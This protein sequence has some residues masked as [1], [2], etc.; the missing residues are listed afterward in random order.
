MKRSPDGPDPKLVDSI[1]DRALDLPREERAGFVQRECGGDDRLAGRLLR[2]LEAAERAEAFLET[3]VA[4][5]TP[6]LLDDLLGRGSGGTQPAP[7]LVLGRYRILRE[8]GRG[9]MGAVYLAERAD[10]QYERQVA[11]KLVPAGLGGGAFAK[12]FE[13]ERRILA[14]LEHPCI[15]RLYDAGSTPEGTPYLVMEYVEG[16]PIDRY[17]EEEDLSVDQRL[18]LFEQVCRA[19]E[20]AHG[21]LIVH[22]DLKPSNILVT[23]DGT[24]KLLDFGVARLLEPAEDSDG[25]ATADP[26]TIGLRAL[27]PEYASPEQLRGERVTT[28]A[29]VWALGVLLYRLLAGRHPYRFESRSPIEVERTITD[30]PPERPSDA[31][32]SGDGSSVLARDLRGD[33]DNVVLA[34]LRPDPA[35]RYGPAAALRTDLQNYLA[36]FP[37]RARPDT[38]RYRAVKFVRRHRA[39][40]AATSLVL[41]AL[42]AG[43]GGVWWQARATAR[44]AARAQATRDYLIGMFEGL[45]PDAAGGQSV[46]AEELLDHGTARLGEELAGQPEVRAEVAGV[47]GTLYRR[48]G[49]YDKG[50]P[51]LEASHES[52]ARLHGEISPEATRAASR[53]ASLLYEAGELEQAEA[54]AREA[55]SASRRLYGDADTAVANALSGLAAIRSARG[56]YDEAAEL[57]GQALAIDRA[58]GTPQAVAAD[59]DNLGV[60]QL[61]RA[62]LDE[63]GALMEE[64]L[65]IRRELHGDDHTSVATGLM[66]LGTVRM[67]AGDYDAA[68]DLFEESLS[69]RRRLLGEGHP[70]VAVALDNLGQAQQ[71][72]GDLE[73]A[74]AAHREALAIRIAAFGEDHPTVA[75]TQNQLAVVEYF[76]GDYAGAAD[77]FEKVARI[78]IA[79]LGEEHPDV[80]S[81]L[82]NLGAARRE[83]GDY[84]AA[85]PVLRRVLD[86]RRRTLGDEHPDVAQSLN[87]LALVLTARGDYAEA[88]EKYR[89]AIALWRASLGED[90][91]TV[92]FGLIGLGRMLGRTGRWVEAE[93]PLREAVALREAGM[94]PGSSSVASARADLGLCLVQL[95]RMEE[96]E[97]LLRA[98][99][100]VIEEQWGPDNELNRRVRAALAEAEGTP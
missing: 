62:E 42:L 48:L 20:Y 11:V 32:K 70:N 52:L 29:D 74:E 14:S 83:A 75:V 56:E 65:A 64:S 9:G 69:I 34:A 7:G 80:L 61:R 90:H 19:V 23:A 27:T 45:D 63:A 13:E 55:L 44:E 47:L 58:H 72:R 33:L 6:E 25:T 24:P 49:L 36:G 21:Q 46:T 57:H 53:L 79:Q 40:A 91:P 73:A 4:E 17:C 89:E 31:R 18:R 54:V 97:P 60:V 16:R 81:V 68:V 38:W 2:L 8:I 94:D 5:H 37:V 43:V 71:R 96:A 100:P 98:A 88:E 12:R 30:Q 1:L 95:G 87:N 51:L 26:T 22:R 92:A 10:A 59:L 67:E 66:N 84:A 3:P 85:E 99:L 86:I 41:L 35:R 82:N 93:V 50:R 76:R 78:L 15:A 39:G 77:R 28:A